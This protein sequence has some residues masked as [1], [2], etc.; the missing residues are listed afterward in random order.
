MVRKSTKAS[1]QKQ[2]A[3]VVLEAVRRIRSML[4]TTAGYFQQID[5]ATIQIR[6]AFPFRV[7]GLRC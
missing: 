6:K 1:T 3:T 5:C 7:P 4:R 2:L